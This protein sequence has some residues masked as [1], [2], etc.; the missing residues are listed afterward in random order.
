MGTILAMTF[1]TKLLSVAL[2]CFTLSGCGTDG[3]KEFYGALWQGTK[4]A[5]PSEKRDAE[6]E[7][8]IAAQKEV[9][10]Q[11]D[12]PVIYATTTNGRSPLIRVSENGPYEQW[13]TPSKTAATFRSGFLTATRG[14]GGDLMNADVEESINRLRTGSTAPATRVHRYLNGENKIVTRSFV[15]IF[16]THPTE[17]INVAGR[18]RTLRKSSETCTNIDTTIENIYWTDPGDGFLWKSKQWASVFVD[19]VVFER[20]TR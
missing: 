16:K 20:T 10:A 17:Q 11:L 3:Q 15:C 14:F 1:I 7:Q 18:K 2:A 4:A 9:L 5:I 13:H 19:S 8:A 12:Q 6:I